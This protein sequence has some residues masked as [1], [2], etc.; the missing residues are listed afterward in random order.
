MEGF[1]VWHKES[2]AQKH[3]VGKGRVWLVEWVKGQNSKPG[4][5]S[6]WHVEDL[7]VG[8]PRP[9]WGVAN[10]GRGPRQPSNSLDK[11]ERERYFS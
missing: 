2:M 5:D 9:F 8:R 3:G 10:Q 11:S 4:E 1:H 6:R 7:E